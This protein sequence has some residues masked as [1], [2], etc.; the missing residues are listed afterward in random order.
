MPN[1]PPP[2]VPNFQ[3]GVGRLATDRYDFEAHITGANY[4]HQAN[5]IDLFPTVVIGGDG[6][7]N[8][9]TAIQ[10]LAANL[11]PPI[12]PT[13]TTSLG[14]IQL[15]GDL[16]GVNT[17]A[18][19][20]KVAGLQGRPISNG[21]PTTNQLLT[22]N[23]SAWGPASASIQSIGGD[24]TG[25]LGGTTVSAI[26]GSSPFFINPPVL[27]WLATSASP[28][29]TQVSAISNVA[30]QSLTIQAQGAYS[31]ATGGNVIGG[32]TYINGGPGTI[33]A[34]D[35]YVFLNGAIKMWP[36]QGTQASQLGALYRV[37]L[38]I[39]P[40]NNNSANIVYQVNVPNNRVC[41]IQV[42]CVGRNQSSSSSMIA[43][44]IFG[45]F[46]C[47]SSTVT[48]VTSGTVAVNA[49]ASTPTT[50]PG[51]LFYSPSGGGNFL[52]FGVSGSNINLVVTYPVTENALYDCQ[53]EININIV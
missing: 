31:G 27:K 25:T 23:G 17:T 22:W 16:G 15:A 26:N 52:S 34:N 35:G 32:S 51:S 53:F 8:V 45:L 50:L 7:S 40:P 5:Q 28:T 42:T 46:Y 14:V 41:F 44:S 49:G 19:S 37:P 18:V 47:A 39:T 1:P 4:R 36:W 9:Q 30:T 6:Y 29:I 12:P 43:A 13:T 38:F 48:Q 21:T 10:A 20:P 3:P 2:I 33:T 11:L 24:V